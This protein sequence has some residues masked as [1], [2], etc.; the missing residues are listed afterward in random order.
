MT[1]NEAA[2]Y[3]PP[4]DPGHYPPRQPG[5]NVYN[6]EDRNRNQL[7]RDEM[8]RPYPPD[9][10]NRENARLYRLDPNLL[11]S[12]EDITGLYATDSRRMPSDY[13]HGRDGD[14]Y[15]YA[16]PGDRYYYWISHICIIS[17]VH[18]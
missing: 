1:A 15:D 12:R 17:I 11:Q 7:Y 10:N 6:G 16:A 13:Y 18:Y 4:Q 3:P 8:A 2:L 5:V 14:R 9:P